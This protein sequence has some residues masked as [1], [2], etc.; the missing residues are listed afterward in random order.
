[1]AVAADT[2]ALPI[3]PSLDE[4]R[5]LA[6]DA[7]A[8]AA[9]PHVHR[10]LRDAGLGVPEAARPQPGAS[11]V[12]ARVGRAGSARRALQLHRHAPALGAALV[13]RRRGRS[14]RARRRGGRAAGARRRCPVCRRSPAASSGYFGYDLVRTVEP[15]GEPNPDEL[16][17]PDMALMLSDVLVIFDHLK[18][19][20]TILVNVFAEDGADLDAAYADAV[21]TIVK[22]RGLLAGPVPRPDDA[23]RAA[24]GA[25]V[26]AEHG[27]RGRSR[28][29][30]R[31]SSSTSTPAT[32]S[33]SCPSQRWSAEIDV[34]P[35]SVYRG[36]RVVNPS[37]Y[38]YF[39]DF[40]RLPDRRRQPRAAADR[41]RPRRLDAAD[42]RHAPA[43]RR[44]RGGRRDR[45][46][47]A[48]GREG[49]RRARDARRPR[50]Q[51]PRARLRVRHRRR[52]DVHG[53]RDLLARHAHRLL[54]LRRRCARKS[55]RWTRCARCCPAGTLSGRAEGPRDAD[56]RRARTVKR[57]GYGGAIG[58]LSYTGDLDTCIH[59]RT[60]VLKD[61]VAHIQAG[62]GTVAD[63]R[64]GLR[65]RGVGQQ[66]PRRQAARSSWRRSRRTGGE[67]EGPRHRQLRLLHLQPRPVPGRARRRARG[68]AQRPRERR[69]AARD[70]RPTASSSRPARA[71]RTRPGSRSRSCAASPR[72]ACRRS[73]S[74]SGTSRWRRPSAATVDPP[75][76]RARQ[77][78]DDRARRARRS[79]P[80]LPSPAHRRPLPLADRRRRQAPGLLRGHGHAAAA[81]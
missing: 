56:H 54:R 37:P 5:E 20:I 50:A 70:A 66:G 6:R 26:R 60:V 24:R 2:T 27:A 17:L 46:G 14:V 21:A 13:A 57:G 11:G 19:T 30:S 22:A 8:R 55:A 40:Q 78:D 62:G 32:P 12:P 48:G 51:R 59:I 81:S 44:R 72:P 28:R 33:R 31:G 61:G 67:R 16:G 4:V 43:R 23:A 49:A 76:A 3:E 69:R 71:R 74:A 29:W 64:P 77:D 41:R 7:H 18:H 1:M 73:A 47:P 53:D 38:M 39:L 45:R 52:R 42:R 10:R 35:F 58:Y 68:R 63:A 9:A 79:S 15:L 80:G 25:D 75:R 65:V 36:L 34:D